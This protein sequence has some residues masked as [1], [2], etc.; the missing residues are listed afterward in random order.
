MNPFG[1]QRLVNYLNQDEDLKRVGEEL[2]IDEA[3]CEF[4]DELH[5]IK[6]VHLVSE[7]NSITPSEIPF[8]NPVWLSDGINDMAI[9]FGPSCLNRPFKSFVRE[10]IRALDLK[11][12]GSYQL[13]ESLDHLFSC[14]SFSISGRFFEW[15][16]ADPDNVEEWAI[17]QGYL[18]KTHYQRQPDLPVLGIS[19]EVSE[20][21]EVESTQFGLSVQRYG[22]QITIQGEDL[23]EMDRALS[24]IEKALDGYLLILGPVG[25]EDSKN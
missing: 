9:S 21:R 16:G 4:C 2:W 6:S 5:L 11:P 24:E 23:Q 14:V 25:W 7:S 19:F 17:L 22:L 10:T 15:E 3:F 13:F 8:I 12:K 1:R 20:S 18:K